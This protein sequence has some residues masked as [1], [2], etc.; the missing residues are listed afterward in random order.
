M[1]ADTFIL[2]RVV[3]HGYSKILYFHYPQLHGPWSLGYAQSLEIRYARIV[4]HLYNLSNVRPQPINKNLNLAEYSLTILY[5]YFKF[6]NS[7][8][9]AYNTT[10]NRYS[11]SKSSL[12]L[13]HNISSARWV[14]HNI[15]Q[16]MGVYY[17][18]TV[19][20]SLLIN[21]TFWNPYK[22]Y[23]YPKLKLVDHS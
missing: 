18:H 20:M 19:H 21:D 8:A 11:F 15:S 10:T 22:M 23:P 4:F 6:I 2:D 16:Y 12:K 1:I 9:R 17:S 13:I 5:S 14:S 7:W 3:N